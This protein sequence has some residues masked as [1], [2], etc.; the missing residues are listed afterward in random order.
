MPPQPSPRI[1]AP[2]PPTPLQTV[3]GSN[4]YHHGVRWQPSF[5]TSGALPV[6]SPVPPAPPQGYNARV[7]VAHFCSPVLTTAGIAP[8]DLKATKEYSDL[9]TAIGQASPEILRQVLRDNWE[10][11][12]MG[13]DYH[14]S[15]IVGCLLYTTFASAQYLYTDSTY[16]WPS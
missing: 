16:E 11:C 15:F 5:T 8:T 1:V 9:S 6:Y 13:S 10:K 12:L 4:G 14:L 3:P 2:E 7:S